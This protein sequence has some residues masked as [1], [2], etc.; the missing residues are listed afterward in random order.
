MTEQALGLIDARVY[1]GTGQDGASSLMAIT[2]EQIRA[3]RGLLRWEQRHLAKACKLALVTIKSIEQRP[4]PL[5]VRTSSLY[6]IVAAFEKAGVEFFDSD[7]GGAGVR[8]KRGR[9]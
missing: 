1:N 6:A 8:F 5:M 4:G 3:A 2:S 9:R 7:N